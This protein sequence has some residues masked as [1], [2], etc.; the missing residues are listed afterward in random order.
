[1]SLFRDDLLSTISEDFP[2][3]M[4]HDIIEKLLGMYCQTFRYF[5]KISTFPMYYDG[6]KNVYFLHLMES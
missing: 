2:L 6:F 3:R 1:M 4:E 5:A